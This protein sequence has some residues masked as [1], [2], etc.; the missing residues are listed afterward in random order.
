M[1]TSFEH[2]QA[3]TM[4]M[5][6]TWTTRVSGT[7]FHKHKYI[8]APTVAPEDVV[9]TAAGRLAEALK[10]NLPHNLG[11]T[12]LEE[13][14]RLG[15]LFGQA[16]APAAP[17]SPIQPARPSPSL[18]L[19]APPPRRSPRLI[20]TVTSEGQIVAKPA[21]P[22]TRPVNPPISPHGVSSANPV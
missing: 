22:P 15:T 4:W 14:T 18:G 7:I 1:G 6:D 3:W 21:K 13:L 5:K 20:T 10:G 9:I 16:A 12:S 11:K 19:P 17:V 8:S 2:Y